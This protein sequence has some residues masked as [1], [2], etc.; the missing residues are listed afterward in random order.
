MKM[1]DIYMKAIETGVNIDWRGRDAIEHIFQQAKRDSGKPDFDQDRLFNPYG[2]TRMAFGDPDTEVLAMLV[3]IEIH[4]CHILQVAAMRQI[5]M[6]VDLALSH[7]LSCINRGLYYFDDILD[8]HNYSLMEVG[9]PSA[10]CDRV[11]AEWKND[12]RYEW[13]MDTINMARALGVP[14]MNI[15]TPC[16]LFNVKNIR[17]TFARMKN[18]TLGE[19]AA[20]LSEATEEV[21]RTPHERYFI[22][23]D[24]NAK[25]GKVYVPIGAG[26]TVPLNLFR[27]VCDAGINTVVFVNPTEGHCRMADECA[28]NILDVPHNSNDNYGINRMLDELEKPGP[29]T[30]Y[31]A[32]DFVRVERGK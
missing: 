25:P 28:V 22:R 12:I 9:V 31:E 13:K 20:E 23:G 14:L 29:L 3:G 19:I 5:G 32:H 4:P 1:R 26:W 2:D 11:L 18:A 21:R 16:D 27:L 7:H 10:Q 17:E 15:H 8:I 24:Q 30:I 6:R